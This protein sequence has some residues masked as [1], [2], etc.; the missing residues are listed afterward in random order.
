MLKTR[1]WVY[2]LILIA[3]I[4]LLGCKPQQESKAPGGKLKIVVT[5]NIIADAVRNLVRD[6]AEVIALMGPGVDPHLYKATQ[7]D[8]QKLQDADI[9]IYNGLHLEGKMA[10]LFH[11]LKNTKPVFAMADALDSTQLRKAKEF[12]DAYDP[13][14]WFD[15]NLWAKAVSSCA[16][17][18]MHHEKHQQKKATYQENA[19][20]YVSTL[21]ELHR[22]IKTKLH[23]IPPAQRVLIT[24]HD[25]F[26][27]FGRAY[28]LEVRGL[29][30]ISTTA[31]Y[32]LKDVSDLVR[33]ITERKIKAVFVESSISR[34]SIESVI[35][36]CSKRG[37]QVKLGGTLYSDALD[38]SNK[39][40]G[41]Y[42]GMVLHNVETIVNALK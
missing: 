10:E 14:I 29:Q 4:W 26:G 36:G 6:S 5:T 38:A 25:A 32:G 28:S 19:T 20:R 17:F 15:V 41:T 24:A 42:A 27:Y 13:H 40:A 23:E 34:K 22:S 30:G 9:I 35:D 21:Q 1:S 7:G 31:E 37:H 2:G 33:V 8:V 16:Q 18:L 3:A 11:K 12:N 39:P